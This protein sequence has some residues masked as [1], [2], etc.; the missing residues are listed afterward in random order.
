MAILEAGG[1]VQA[2]AL[3]ASMA[4]PSLVSSHFAWREGGEVYIQELAWDGA[5]LTPGD[6]MPLP[7]DPAYQAGDQRRPA[8]AKTGDWIWAA[9]NDL[10]IGQQP[11]H[12]NV[13]VSLMSTPIV[14]GGG[15]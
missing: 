6:V 1:G 7:H 3:A 14:H 8:L 10:Q 9:W 15:E 11:K 13:R 4:E 5:T 12:G 2:E